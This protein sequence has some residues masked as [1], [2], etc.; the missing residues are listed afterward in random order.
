M[1]KYRKPKRGRRSTPVTLAAPTGGLNGRDALNDQAPE[2]AFRLENWIPNN[3]SADT[4]GGYINFS[5]GLPGAVESVEVYTGG[6]ASKMLAFSNGGIYDVTLG[7]VVGAAL[8]GGTGK[9]SNKVTTAMF[10]NAGAQLL[11]I[12]SGADAP[13]SYD[14]TTLTALVITGAGSQL[15]LH[16]PHA[17]KG[18]LLMCQ[19]DLCGFYYLGVGAIQGAASFFDLQ[20]QSMKGGYLATITSFSQDSGNGPQD[21]CLFVTSEGEYIV[22]SGFDPS[23]AANWNLVARYYGPPPIGKKGWFKFRS[24]VYFITE[25][26]VISFS[27]IR[28]LGEAQDNTEYLTDKLG[29]FF[30]EATTYKDTHGWCGIIYPRGGALYI[31]VPMTGAVTGQYTQFVMNTN[32]K[33]GAWTQFLGWNALSWGLFNRRAY[34]GT[35]DGRVCLADEGFTDNGA[36]IVATCRQAWNTYDDQHGMGEANKQFHLVTFAV[37]ADGA[38]ALSCALNVNYEDDDPTTATPITAPSG[39]DWD[40]ADWDTASWAGSAAT[41]YIQV[42][43]GKFGYIASLWMRAVST[44]AVIKWFASR[45][46]LEKTNGVIL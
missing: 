12:Y 23:A 37:A 8:A 1:V 29:R 30:K 16:S 10:S 21:Y 41:Q 43:V 28:Q 17:F 4:R 31:N 45:V 18:R 24:D 39:S 14:G 27:E 20:Q 15:T 7:G 35:S 19:K 2:D 40:T 33:K 38:P 44:A 25:E 22:Y 11:Q 36:G 9:N 13:L 5:T 42:P 3:T 26:G 34:Y 6:A 32:S 46:V